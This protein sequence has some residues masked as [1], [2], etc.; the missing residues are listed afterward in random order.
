MKDQGT[1]MIETAIAI[2]LVI[3]LIIGIISLAFGSYNKIIVVSAAREGAREFAV[4]GDTEV[5]LMAIERVI[6]LG[7]TQRLE[8]EVEFAEAADSVEVIISAKQQMFAPGLG[9]LLYSNNP[10]SNYLTLSGRAKYKKEGW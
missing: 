5:S 2:P 8:Y 10:T 4:T 7:V 9:A 6:S 3:F 1:S